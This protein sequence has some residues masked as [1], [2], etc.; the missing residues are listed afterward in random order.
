ML[1]VPSDPTPLPNVQ[2]QGLRCLSEY[3]P[4]EIPDTVEPLEESEACD[5]DAYA[6]DVEDEGDWDLSDLNGCPDLGHR[7]SILVDYEEL[8]VV[9]LAVYLSLPTSVVD[10]AHL[11]IPNVPVLSDPPAAG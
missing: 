1:F 7:A 8:R 4:Y 11:A 6:A 3:H 5:F 2:V 10:I 9:C